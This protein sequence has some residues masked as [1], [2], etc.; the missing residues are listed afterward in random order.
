MTLFAVRS[1]NFSAVLIAATLLSPAMAR[2]DDCKVR[3]LANEG[4]DKLPAMIGN[5]K[6][7]ESR[8]AQAETKISE[9]ETQLSIYGQASGLVA[10]FNR[11]PSRP[12]PDKW[13]L[14]APASGR[15]VVGAGDNDNKDL[16]GNDLSDRT[17]GTTSGEEYNRLIN[18]QLP[19]R[20]VE[21][22]NLVGTSK[23]DRYNAGGK[24]YWVVVSTKGNIEV[25][26]NSDPVRNM[27]PF[28][29][30]YYCIKE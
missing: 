18:D 29:A 22:N 9:L 24:D 3:D 17:V 28:V 7:L 26:G 19:Q 30:L 15:F 10:A 13:K 6:C 4:T 11:D 23:T 25:G 27:P 8:L 1:W 2:A 12:C 21:I 16:N 5:F 14:F 20:Q